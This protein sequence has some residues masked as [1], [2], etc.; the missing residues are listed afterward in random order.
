MVHHKRR[1]WRAA[2]VAAF[3]LLTACERATEPRE[4]PEPE[5]WRSYSAVRLDSS[6]VP[7]LWG[8]S[9]ADTNR[10]VSYEIE[11]R[12]DGTT[13]YR[14]AFTVSTRPDTFRVST[15]GAHAIVADSLHLGNVHVALS[16]STFDF[17]ERIGPGRTWRF[18]LATVR[19]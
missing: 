8:I 16:D 6:P 11:L 19:R 2:V 10:L 7:L 13:A 15:L 18:R 17:P 12:V 3:A 14:S 4:V 1:D 9:G 5:V